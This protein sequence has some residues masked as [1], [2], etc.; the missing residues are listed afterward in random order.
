MFTSKASATRAKRNAFGVSDTVLVCI[1]LPKPRK[2]VEGLVVKTK[3]NH[4]KVKYRVGDKKFTYW[5]HEA[6]NE[7]KSGR[8]T[9]THD[10]PRRRRDEP[11]LSANTVETEVPPP[12]P[13]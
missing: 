10:S 2:W 8:L 1:V 6:S 13:G 7:I 5:F 3:A 9:V 11:R 4:V 12:P